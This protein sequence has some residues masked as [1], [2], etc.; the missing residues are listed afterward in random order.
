MVDFKR[1]TDTAKDLVDK[2]GGTDRL[3]EDAAELRNIA[4]GPGSFQDKAKAAVDA[5]KAP[6]ENAEPT[7]GAPPAQTATAAEQARA[8]GKVEGEDR[9]KHGGGGGHGHGRH[10]RVRGQGGGDGDPAV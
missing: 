3:K 6:G 8:A 9:G 2:R 7:A 1:I 4:K 5:L 10:P